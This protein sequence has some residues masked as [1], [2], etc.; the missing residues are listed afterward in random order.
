MAYQSGIDDLMEL[1][2]A[3]PLESTSAQPRAVPLHPLAKEKAK[4]RRRNHQSTGEEPILQV[5]GH[6][7]VDY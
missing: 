3:L 2:S 4:K 1:T 7:G 5:V 6:D